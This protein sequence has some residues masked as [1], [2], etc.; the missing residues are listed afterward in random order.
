MNLEVNGKRVFVA[1]GGLETN[2]D[3]QPPPSMVLVHGAGMDSSV[4]QLQTRHLAHRAKQYGRGPVL[5]VDL[6][7]HGRSEGPPLTSVEDLA[8][9]L[10]DL[11]T[12]CEPGAGETVHDGHRDDHLAGPTIVGHSMGTFIALELA[13]G[14]PQLVGSLVLVATAAAMPVNEVLMNAAR[15]DLPL[16][17][18]LITGWSHGSTA[19]VAPSPSPGLSLTGGSAALVERTAPG[20][21]AT[22]LAAC[23]AYDPVEAAAVVQCP[24][25]LVLGR[26]DKMTPTRAAEPLIQALGPTTGP[27]VITL[28]CGHMAMTEAAADLRAILRS[29]L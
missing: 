28:D 15:A 25:T 1:T 6:P 5:A 18:G 21:L 27:D 14:R 7:G 19:K 11:L 29:K 10:A 9:W 13:A 12:S 3:G 4:W 16:A 22:D 8:Q 26:A 17:A 2:A 24:T 23:A 20:V